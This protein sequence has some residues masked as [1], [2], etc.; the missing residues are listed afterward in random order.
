MEIKGNFVTIVFSILILISIGVSISWTNFKYR[1]E[2][3]NN[4]HEHQIKLYRDTVEYWKI[5]SYML[6]EEVKNQSNYG[7]ENR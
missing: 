6:M 2:Q 7:K 4:I 1:M 5:K 3:T